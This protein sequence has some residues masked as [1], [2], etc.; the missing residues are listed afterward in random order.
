MV[1]TGN[2][3]GIKRAI[4]VAVKQIHAGIVE[5]ADV[6][7]ANLQ[8]LLGGLDSELGASGVVSGALLEIFNTALGDARD[9]EKSAGMVADLTVELSSRPTTQQVLD[10]ESSLADLER[11]KDAAEL[12]LVDI[13]EGERALN[14]RVISLTAQ[15]ARR[16]Q[17]ITDQSET[18]RGLRATLQST[19]ERYSKL[20]TQARSRLDRVNQQLETARGE[21]E[22]SGTGV[23]DELKARL[24]EET[25]KATVATAE[26]AR[27]QEDL[28]NLD[29]ELGRA[30]D[31]I[32]TE[33]KRF[34][35]ADKEVQATKAALIQ[36]E[37]VDIP[38][39]KSALQRAE[40]QLE[41]ERAR[42]AELEQEIVEIRERRDQT[43]LE[44]Q[45]D[46]KEQMEKAGIF[47]AIADLLQE[48]D[49]A[50]VA[51]LLRKKLDELVRMEK[52]IE[53]AE[54]KIK[55]VQDEARRAARQR[56]APRPPVSQSSTSRPAGA[57]PGSTVIQQA[58]L[59]PPA[60]GPGAVGQG[61]GTP[62]RSSM[63]RL[64]QQQG[65][66]RVQPTPGAGQQSG[67]QG[68][69]RPPQGHGGPNSGKA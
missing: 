25:E 63:P 50:K 10:L 24:D 48:N 26:S 27:H 56:P 67:G 5:G 13:R 61:A 31:R 7:V 11:A 1:S 65:S 23:I 15:V 19:R 46:T 20:L 18:L 35:V 22:S 64:P 53:E 40:Q 16:D 34:V 59:Q 58:P 37:S 60:A 51:P 55:K 9:A 17:Q 3:S 68:Q 49:P 66:P 28:D 54:A 21:L 6:D 52:R 29:R 32:I 12:E 39:I 57:A 14:D 2:V 62:A 4:T 45:S 44:L 30:L 41:I 47:D 69:Q 36:K 38:G 8:V 43:I 42:V 33:H